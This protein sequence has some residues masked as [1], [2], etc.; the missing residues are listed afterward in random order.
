MLLLSL[1]GAC[2]CKSAT[3]GSGV[4]DD[5]LPNG[6]DAAVDAGESAAIGGT[7]LAYTVCSCS[8]KAGGSGN[9]QC[10]ELNPSPLQA[11]F[12]HNSASLFDL[13]VSLTKSGNTLKGTDENGNSHKYTLNAQGSVTAFQYNSADSGQAN[14]WSQYVCTCGATPAFADLSANPAG[15]CTGRN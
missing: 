1:S 5:Q 9:D 11:H 14:A 12:S 13:V 6:P 4:K 8:P 2:S 15:N 3:G 7:S 10:F